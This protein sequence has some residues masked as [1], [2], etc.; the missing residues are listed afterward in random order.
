MRLLCTFFSYCKDIGRQLSKER[1]QARESACFLSFPSPLDKVLLFLYFLYN[2]LQFV[3]CI[4]HSFIS[5]YR[6]CPS[7]RGGFFLFK[8]SP[9]LS[10]GCAQQKKRDRHLCLSLF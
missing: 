8:A 3:L 10:T 9:H 4:C 2:I 6:L 5:P 1:K 7:H